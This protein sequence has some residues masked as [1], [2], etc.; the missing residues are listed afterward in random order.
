MARN[1]N[2]FQARELAKQ[3]K[4]IRLETDKFWFFR[5][6]VLWFKTPDNYVVEATEFTDAYFLSNAWT[7][8][9]WI[10]GADGEII[11]PPPTPSTGSGGTTTGGTT[12]TPEPVLSSGSGSGSFGG[13]GFGGSGGGGPVGGPGAKGGKAKP[14]PT[15]GAAADAEI[16]FT[17]LWNY[18]VPENTD[19]HC[20]LGTPT[21]IDLLLTAHVRGGPLGLGTISM[22]VNGVTVTATAYDGY[23]YTH[24]FT[25]ITWTPGVSITASATYD[26]PGSPA[27]ITRTKDFYRLRLCSSLDADS[28]S[29]ESVP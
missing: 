11:I 27:A 21:T 14:K 23:D 7:D 2:W 17:G 18:G 13:G 12:A 28:V 1:L 26:P 8:E 16:T 20:L 29:V 9:D 22:I 24:N 19:R 25:G 4:R 15:P 3:G 5:Q 6:Q 10:V